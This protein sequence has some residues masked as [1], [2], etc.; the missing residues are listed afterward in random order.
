[1]GVDAAKQAKNPD[2]VRPRGQD[3]AVQNLEQMGAAREIAEYLIKL[4]VRIKKLEQ[5]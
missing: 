3:A 2:E 5:D 1:L 4:E